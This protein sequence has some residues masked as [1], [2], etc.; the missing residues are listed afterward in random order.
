MTYD[1]AIVG[2]GFAGLGAAI[3]L[4]QRGVDNVVVL[5]RALDL[6]GT[7]R[8]NTYPGCRCDVASNLYSFSF[9][10]N[11]AW[12]NSY[13][14][15]PEIWRYLQRVANDHHLRDVIKFDHDVHDV[16]FDETTRR[17]RLAT[18]HGDVDAACVVL[19][20]GGLSEPR[21]PL[22]DGIDDFAGP[23]MHTARWD[24]R[25]ELIGR[26][27]GVI[28]T[29]ASAVQAVP[30]IAPLVDTLTLFQRT[31]S[32]ILPHG[33]HTVPPRTRS[34][35]A[36]VPASQRLARAWYYWRREMMVLG[37]VNDPR[38]MSRAE[39]FSR[40]HLDDQVADPQLRERL[41]P[42]YRLG[43]KRVLLSN[44]FY[45]ALT[46]DNV[47]LVTE[48]IDAIEAKGVRTRDGELH[49]LDVIITAT[50]FRV[51]DNP[52]VERVHG[53][54]G[55]TLADVYRGVLAH[56]K[57]TTFP[58]FPNLFML[59]GPNTGLGHSSIVFMI[60]SQ[61]NYVGEA[62]DVAL[63]TNGLVE[64]KEHLARRW[65]HELLAKMPTTV[66]GSGCSSWYLNEGG[67]N[68]TIWPDFTFR[69]RRATRHFDSRDHHVTPA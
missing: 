38:R 7:W 52:A 69:F 1:V 16:R 31:P 35:F 4:R 22:I 53:T 26:R 41:T 47:R 44:D 17:W 32:W 43:C 37:F 29:G 21:R 58:G 8:D 30:Q 48:T 6:G 56:Y 49:E 12:D 25:V 15:Q 19:A 39:A 66:W 60:E 23:V 63:A 65:T 24:E 64:P 54:N 46:R 14:Y 68:T 2:S 59:A 67:V 55:A 28:G 3:R 10:P 45:P 36:T 33:G 5:E 61:L 62:I 57:G 13:S 11:P 40:Q 18:N 51:T 34:L 42:H 20:T 27:V 50:G 9:A